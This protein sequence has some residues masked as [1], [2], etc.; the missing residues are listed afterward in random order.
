MLATSNASILSGSVQ[1]IKDA[2]SEFRTSSVLEEALPIL[3]RIIYLFDIEPLSK[4]LISVLPT[5]NFRNWWNELNKNGESSGTF[6]I[7]WPHDCGERIAMQV[8]LCRMII[9]EKENDSL[10]FFTYKYCHPRVSK[11][12]DLVAVFA[13]KVL[14]P[15]VRDIDRLVALRPVS[16]IL[17]EA[18]RNLPTSDDDILD[19]LLQEACRKFKDPAPQSL[20]DAV[21]KLWDSLERLK[22]LED[23]K[24]KKKSINMLL[25]KVTEDPLF[26][27]NLN[28]EAI[29]LTAIGNKFQ[30][31]HFETDKISLSQKQ[32]EYLFHRLYSLIRFLLLSQNRNP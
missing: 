14:D 28:Q 27:E 31:R 16:P 1:Q 6:A 2:I 3:E 9:R 19:K 4:F 20:Q 17:L 25:E 13:K 12:S 32:L 22:T 10:R 15:F 7:S 21:E 23:P 24:D 29:A 26:R 11:I 18:M 8:E 5:I 30:I